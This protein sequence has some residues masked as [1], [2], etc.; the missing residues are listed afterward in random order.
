[1]AAPDNRRSLTP[2]HSSPGS[3]PPSEHEKYG[4]RFLMKQIA[5]SSL[6]QKPL[7]L[8]SAFDLWKKTT[9]SDAASLPETS[10]TPASAGSSSEVKETRG[11]F[12]RGHQQ[13]SFRSQTIKTVW[14]ESE[15]G[16]VGG[17]D[18]PVLLHHNSRAPAS[19]PPSTSPSAPFR[20]R[21]LGQS[22]TSSPSSGLDSRPRSQSSPTVGLESRPDANSN[23][24]SPASAPQRAGIG[25]RIQ[26]DPPHRVISLVPMGPAARSGSTIYRLM[27]AM[28]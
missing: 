7:D 1:M 10:L 17:A 16:K 13:G 9:L 15:N 27:I 21:Y 3:G 18:D 25:M 14:I 19:A 23:V 12:S 4:P 5:Q 26:D 6:H 20:P 24:V 2:N 22:S 8:K 11:I 28:I